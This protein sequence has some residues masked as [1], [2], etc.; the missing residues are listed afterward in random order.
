MAFT[1]FEQKSYPYDDLRTWHDLALL[2][3]SL[4][5]SSFQPHWLSFRTLVIFNILSKEKPFQIPGPCYLQAGPG[6]LTS[7]S[8][9]GAPSHLALGWGP[10]TF[11]TES[12]P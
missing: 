4:I 8:R 9:Y 2:P 12:G 5:P 7:Y 3:V 11:H 6:P 10:L 1:R